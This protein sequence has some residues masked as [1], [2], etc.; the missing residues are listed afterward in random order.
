MAL[1]ELA[2]NA[3]KH[4]ALSQEG[5][6]V[7]LVW[8]AGSGIDGLLLRWQESGGPPV[9]A[10]SRTRFGTTLIRVMPAR[11]L[12]STVLDYRPDGLFWELSCGRT[13]YRSRAVARRRR[14]IPPT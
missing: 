5:G 8:Q 13:R 7:S 6:R 14:M 9:A 12:G 4:G 1:H 10:P 3:I 11:S 2:T